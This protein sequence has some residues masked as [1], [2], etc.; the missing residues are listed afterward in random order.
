M[1]FARS[2]MELLLSQWEGKKIVYTPKKPRVTLTPIEK[3][4]LKKLKGQGSKMKANHENTSLNGGVRINRQGFF[5]KQP[6]KASP[7]FANLKVQ[8]SK[9]SVWQMGLL[10]PISLVYLVLGRKWLEVRPNTSF[11]TPSTFEPFIY[12]TINAS[13]FSQTFLT[14]I[15]DQAKIIKSTFKMAKTKPSNSTASR[16]ASA[17]PPPHQRTG[18]RIGKNIRNSKKNAQRSKMRKE[19]RKLLAKEAR[20]EPNEQKTE[21]NDAKNINNTT[22]THPNNDQ[23]SAVQKNNREKKAA[24]RAT[25]R[26]AKKAGEEA[27]KGHDAIEHNIPRFLIGDS[28]K[29]YP[30]PYTFF[31]AKRRVLSSDINQYAVVMVDANP[32]L[33]AG[34]IAFLIDAYQTEIDRLRA[35]QAMMSKEEENAA[36]SSP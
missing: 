19:K 23:A 28:R 13:A 14:S 21:A 33:D 11:P 31:S 1:H 32:Q 22:K 27:P 20:A 17:A 5:K 30:Y 15:K 24:R 4:E 2:A 12:V 26:A 36:T 9:L 25:K 3:N 16:S 7:S 10:T 35:L 8:V 18:N 6:S 29:L 34:T